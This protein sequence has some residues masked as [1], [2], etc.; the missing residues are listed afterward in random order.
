MNNL[1]RSLLVFLDFTT[2]TQSVYINKWQCD[3][4]CQFLS[5]LYDQAKMSG[6]NETVFSARKNSSH[7]KLGNDVRA[8]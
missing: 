1:Q 6:C 8:N 5:S 3:D 4:L 7:L 2:V